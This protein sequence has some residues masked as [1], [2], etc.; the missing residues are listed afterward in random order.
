[1]ISFTSPQRDIDFLL[2]DLFGLDKQWA[3]MPGLQEVNAELAQAVIAEG[4]RI[5]SEVLAP[6]ESER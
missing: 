5:A 3:D 4:G 2:F 6:R 1:M